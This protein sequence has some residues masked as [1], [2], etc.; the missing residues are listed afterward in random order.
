MIRGREKEREKDRG[1]EKES[2]TFK[3]FSRFIE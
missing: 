2:I 1:K 3:D